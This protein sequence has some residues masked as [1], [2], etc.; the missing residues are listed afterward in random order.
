MTQI[1]SKQNLYLVVIALIP[2]LNQNTSGL[3][4]YLVNKQANKKSK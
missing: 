2:T 3:H 1:L 4:K